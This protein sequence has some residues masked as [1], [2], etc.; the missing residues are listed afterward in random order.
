MEFNNHILGTF[1]LFGMQVNFTET[2]R[3][4]YIVMAIIIILAVAARIKFNKFQE[5]PK[6]FQNFLELIVESADAFIVSNMGEK[7]SY[8]CSW[9]FTVMLFAGLCCMSGILM[10]PPTADLATTGALGITTFCL[11]NFLPMIKRPKHY[12]KG[13]IE[14]FA[15]FLPL[16]LLDVVTKPFSL[17]FRMFGNILGGTIIMGMVYAMPVYLKIGI[18]SVLHIYF[19]VFAAVLQAFIFVMLSMAFI[20]EKMSEEE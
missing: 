1:N 9:F 10:R 11:I 18:P 19:D 14:P 6:G 3:N 2:Y 5:I 16:N 4:T 17:S 20:N 12:F 15:L 8:L 13:F 7:C